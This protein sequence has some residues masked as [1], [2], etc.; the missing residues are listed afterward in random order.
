[1][2]HPQLEQCPLFQGLTPEEQAYALSYF[3]AKTKTYEKGEFLH[4]V[5]FP[6]ERFGLVL[7]GT[8]QVYMDDMDGHH[9]IMNSVGAG[10]LFGEAY[11]FLGTDAPI[12]ICARHGIGNSLDESQPDQSADATISS[13]GLG[14]VQP[15]HFR[16]GHPDAAHEPANSD[17]LPQHPADEADHLSL[18]IRRCPGRFL[19]RSL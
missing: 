9:I 12:Y 15:L 11:C 14:P 3:D 5:S 17:S 16:P 1:M 19:Y 7:S 13:L 6:L 4:H 18:P 2:H 10:G 8:V